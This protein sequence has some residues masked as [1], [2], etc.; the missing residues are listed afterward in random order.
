MF[1]FSGIT[2]KVDAFPVIGTEDTG[3][4]AWDGGQKGGIYEKSRDNKGIYIGSQNKLMIGT[5]G[6]R[7][8]VCGG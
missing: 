8:G 5:K 6:G 7:F 1:H 2:I 4:S 3:H